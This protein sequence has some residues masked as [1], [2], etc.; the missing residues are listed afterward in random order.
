M[1]S[2]T[3]NDLDRET[4]YRALQ[5]RDGRFDGRFYTAVI[6]TGIYCR[7]ICPAKTPR[8]ENCLFLPSAGAAHHLGFRP[9]LRC[10]PEAA[11]G[12]AG[13]RGTAGT[14]G[15]ALHL[16]AE[17]GLD[18]A[19]VDRLAERLGIGS[20]HLR[21]LFDRHVGASPV[22]VA[23]SHRILFAKR[24][25]DETGLPM[26][27]VAL[28]AGF[29]SIRRFNDVFRRTYGR[30]PSQLRR[31]GTMAGTATDITLR[32]PFTSPY[33]WAA[34]LDFLGSRAIPGVESVEDGVYR[35][36]FLLAA[37]P[38]L[39]EVRRPPNETHLLATI[40]TEAVGILAAVV[41]RLRR[42]FDLDADIAAIDAHLAGSPELA[43]RIRLR[44]GIRV[45]GAWDDFELAVRAILGQQVSVAAATTMAGR[46][47][48]AYGPTLP[49]ALG[50]GT[51]TRI[52]PAP[53]AIA[54][55]DLTGIG[56]TG[57]RA[58]ALA[59]L[60]AALS[61]R[62]DLLAV[63]ETLEEKVERLCRLPGIGP[64]T[65]NYIAMRMLREPDAFPSA[66]L[67]LLRALETSA[68]RPTP[69][70]LLRMA[71][72]WRPWRAYAALR[73]WTQE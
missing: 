32:L 16:I 47:A 52:F 67:G 60:G 5:S 36:S 40:H 65:A 34:M 17:G 23:Q 14:V 24:L 3:P 59:G 6:S 71:E 48:A 46:L 53:A 20:R 69:S 13:W 55:A 33:D 4:C 25:I 62:P 39:V 19:G 73:L 29:G 57:K 58:A 21:R 11:P 38:G 50:N 15:R 22:A 51:V 64:W 35:R 28:A 8:I 61:A 45:P 10:R 66:D 49:P 70:A 72:A 26:A 43:Q 27:D 1:I 9:C 37:T 63:G 30:P 31:N 68:G 42:L 54:T 41:A 2:D 7:P 18:E 56:V 44:P 12:S